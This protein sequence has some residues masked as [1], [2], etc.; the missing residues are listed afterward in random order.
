MNRQRTFDQDIRSFRA[1]FFAGYFG[2]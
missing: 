1:F 2:A